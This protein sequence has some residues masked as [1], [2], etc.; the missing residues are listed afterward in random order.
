[1]TSW[2]WRDIAAAIPF[3]KH[4]ANYSQFR[5]SFPEIPPEFSEQG[6]RVPVVIRAATRH[7]S[8]RSQM[9]KTF[10]TLTAVAALV[11]GMSMASAQTPSGMQNQQSK[12]PSAATKST[13]NNPAKKKTATKGNGK[14]CA[15]SAPGGKMN[16]KYASIEACQ[17]DPKLKGRQCAANPGAGTTGS[18]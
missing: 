5:L 14:F 18:N 2:P 3:I 6:S 12:A 7:L 10:T 11:V 16:C 13:A 17:Q 9:M 4:N 8:S 1:M 15:V